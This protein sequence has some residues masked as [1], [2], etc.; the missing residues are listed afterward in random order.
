[1]NGLTRALAGALMV[2]VALACGV[3]APEVARDQQGIST[4]VSSTLGALTQ[5]ATTQVGTAAPSGLSVSFPGGSLMIPMG[6]GMGVSS[7]K[8]AA[9]APSEDSPWWEQAPEHVR[10]KVLGYPLQG[11]FHEPQVVIYP[12]ADFA[13]MNESVAANIQVLQG[14]VSN[15]SSAPVSTNLP[16]IT[17]FNAGPIF[18]SQVAVVPFQ[19]GY[20]IRALTEYAQYSAPIN[21]NDLFYHFQ[22]LTSEGRNYIVAILPITA[23]LLQAESSE[24]STVPAGGVPFPGYANPDPA[25]LSG[26]YGAVS[27]IL[28]ATSASDFSP[29][30]SDL[31]AFVGSLMMS[32]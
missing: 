17:F 6:L 18:Q 22:G 21:N 8:V 11:K 30:L 31:D 24:S 1:M 26:Y 4:I 25:V 19:G 27:G 32:P 15:P 9:V 16:S 28:D 12:A 23:P 10:L 14:V 2:G 13:S 7:E 5:V 20:G 29:S 3:V